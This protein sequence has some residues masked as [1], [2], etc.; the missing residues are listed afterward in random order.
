[1]SIKR[2]KLRPSLEM[3]RLLAKYRNELIERRTHEEAWCEKL[4]ERLGEDFIFQKGFYNYCGFYI[5]DFY[6]P[7]GG[8]CLEIDGEYH[9]EIK[10]DDRMRD[11]YLIEVRHL[12]VLRITNQ[13]ILMMDADELGRHLKIKRTNR[14]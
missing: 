4:L 8:I 7:V 9:D 11:R 13:D 1:M 10:E 2:K 14:A 3:Q 6:L 5:I 12:K